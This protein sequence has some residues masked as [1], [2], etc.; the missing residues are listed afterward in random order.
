MC[1]GRE[2]GAAGESGGMG[3]NRG[4]LWAAALGLAAAA[5]GPAGGGR[6]LTLQEAL[7]LAYQANPTLAAARSDLKA[8]DE[9][10]PQAAS[11]FFRPQV[12]AEAVYGRQRVKTTERLS[13]AQGSRTEK[14]RENL[15]DRYAQLTV[16]L[17]L[18]R[19][20]ATVAGV[21]A[22]NATVDAQEAS[23]RGTEQS[24]LAGVVTA[25]ADV[26]LSRSAAGFAQDS[27]RELADLRRVTADLLARQRSTVTDLAQIDA[28]V[29]RARGELAQRRAAVRS[30]EAEFLRAVG[31]PPAALEPRPAL[32]EPVAS[33]EQGLALA[34]GSHPDVVAARRQVDADAASV[35]QQL[36][37]LLPQLD[38]YGSLSYQ[39]DKAHYSSDAGVPNYD[40]VDREVTL[41][42]GVQLTVPLYTGGGQ[43]AAV[44]QAKQVLARDRQALRATQERV[45]ADV[46]GAWADLEAARQALRDAED[47]VAASARAY[48]GL[49]RRY[50]DRTTTVQEVLIA[51]NNRVQAMGLREAARRQRLVAAADLAAAAGRLDATALGL[52]T[53]AYDARAYRAGSRNRLLGVSVDD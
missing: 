27:L 5:V 43:Y 51:Q 41:E 16:D 40:E 23:L 47:Q 17:P 46:R 7:V 38:A 24:V 32:P 42:A 4:L 10:V 3:A 26:L 37:G 14:N 50:R 49:K 31:E 12:N 33:L 48:E 52:P 1:P 22:A 30:A 20:G 8:T 21:A 28:E 18:Y 45:D 39:L 9:L 29:A 36:G 15:K 34:A 6:A 2:A 25:Y 11:N 19:G 35:R 13:D 53:P 44:R